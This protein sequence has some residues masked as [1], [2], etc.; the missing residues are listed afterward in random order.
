MSDVEFIE[1]RGLVMHY[2][3]LYRRAPS[4]LPRLQL[5]WAVSRRTLHKMRPSTRAAQDL[6]PILEDDGGEEGGAGGEASGGDT[7]TETDDDD[8]GP[9]DR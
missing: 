7:P 4:R 3:T 5:A 9:F 1:C 8:S 2:L 6:E